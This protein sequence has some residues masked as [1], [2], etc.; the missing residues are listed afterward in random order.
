MSGKRDFKR[1]ATEEA[2]RHSGDSPGPARIA[3]RPVPARR[4]VAAHGRDVRLFSGAAGA[5]L[6]HRRRPH[7]AHG[8]G[9]ASTASFCS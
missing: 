4:S 2:W 3:A 9:S 1:I 5:A 6:R 8:R 7:P